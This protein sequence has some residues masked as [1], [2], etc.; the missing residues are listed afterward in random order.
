VQQSRKASSPAAASH[1]SARRKHSIRLNLTG[2]EKV[3]AE[4]G[5]RAI[6]APLREL[7]DNAGAPASV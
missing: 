4:I 3:G 5:R 7:A 2:D 1:S 6:E